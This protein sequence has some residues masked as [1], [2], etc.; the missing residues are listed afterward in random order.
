MRR[1]VAALAVALL[2]TPA[3]AGPELGP[4][5]RVHAGAEPIDTQVGHAAP[6]LHDMDGDG[7][8]DLLVGQMGQGLM[9]VYRNT[10]TATAPAFA[11]G[12]VFQADGKDGTVEAG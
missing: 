2:A 7:L 9:R 8:R 12:E 6:F 3:L 1:S 4:P 10:G 5:V 11:A